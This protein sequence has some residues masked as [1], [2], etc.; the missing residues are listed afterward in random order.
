MHLITTR[1]TEIDLTMLDDRIVPVRDV[2]RTI[3]SDADVDR[4]EGPVIR[5][6]QI[7][8]LFSDVAA[9][10]RRDFKSIGAIATEVIGHP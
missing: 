3:G 2:E 10:T 9:A 5:G 6:L 4:T 8:F 1:I 7:L